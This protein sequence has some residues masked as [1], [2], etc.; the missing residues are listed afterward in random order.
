MLNTVNT[1][2]IN[3]KAKENLWVEISK[4]Q[5][6]IK[7]YSELHIKSIRSWRLGHRFSSTSHWDVLPCNAPR[8][9]TS[10][11]GVSIPGSPL[12]LLPGNQH[13]LPPGATS[14]HGRCSS[15]FHL[16][17]EKNPSIGLR[18]GECAGRNCIIK[19]GCAANHSNQVSTALSLRVE[20]VFLSVHQEMRWGALY[21]MGR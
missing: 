5:R 12:H 18:K 6:V 17:A 15:T 1:C 13:W 16:Q 3:I 7:K 20:S 10:L 4:K 8:G 19:Q 14:G 11:Y 9:T 21:Y 2:K